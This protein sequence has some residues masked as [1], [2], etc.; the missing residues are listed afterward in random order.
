MVRAGTDGRAEVRVADA[1]DPAVLSAFA[2]S[3]ERAGG[4][5]D[6]RKPG[7]PVVLAGG[8]GS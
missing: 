5:A 1:G 6:K 8:I 4:S 2:L 3:L 7:G